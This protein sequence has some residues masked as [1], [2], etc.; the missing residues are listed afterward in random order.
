[1]FDGCIITVV[2]YMAT[3]T[4][5]MR[6]LDTLKVNY[7]VVEYPCKEALDGVEVAK[8]LNADVSCVFK[9]LVTIAPSKNHYVFL[10]PANKELDLKK[11]AKAVNEKSIAM[12]PMKDLLPTTGY[13][14]GGCSPFAMKKV[15]PTVI[16]ES[17]I[18]T[19]KV[20]VSGGKLGLQLQIASDDLIESAK[21]LVVNITRD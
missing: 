5:A 20:Y 16:D 4:N 7:D 21:A 14:R 15:F 1:M 8:K 12:I 11:C 2:M 10:L 18:L 13:V 17:I 9:T 3:K 19:E 6:Y